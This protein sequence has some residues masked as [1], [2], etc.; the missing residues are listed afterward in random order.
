MD[1]FSELNNIKNLGVEPLHY[2]FNN[3]M[4]DTTGLLLEFGVYTGTSINFTASKTTATVYGFDSFEGLPE[5]WGR[6]DILFNKGAFS[7]NGNLPPVLPNVRLI[8]GWFDQSLPT[9]LK[10]HTGPITY[11]HI[12][13]DIYSSTKTIFDLTK[14]QIAPGCIIVFDEL[15]NYPGF[16]DHEWKAWWELINSSGITFEWIGMNGDIQ[17]GVLRDRG[18]YDQKVAVKILTNPLYA[19][20][21]TTN[22]VA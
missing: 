12:D 13:C 18:A 19:K 20:D 6:T 5:N 15:I 16:E 11:L 10:D 3:N 22:P 9:F 1:R 2:V 4:V 8:K 14:T 17:S 21:D 7:L